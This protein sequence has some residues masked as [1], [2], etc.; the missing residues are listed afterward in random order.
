MSKLSTLTPIAAVLAVSVAGVAHAADNP[1]AL[2]PATGVVLADAHAGKEGKCG[3][4][5]TMPEGK[6]GG[7]KAK[8][9][10]EG[11]CGEGKCG[12]DKKAAAAKAA[13][14]GKCGG[15]KAKGMKEGKCGGAKPADAPAAPPAAQ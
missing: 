5:K 1:F 13:K 14:E 2:K 8:A 9:M 6:C 3:A 12:A 10:P 7:D 4:D 15:D 11:K